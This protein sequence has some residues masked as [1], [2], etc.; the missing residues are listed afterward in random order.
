MAT[1]TASATSTVTITVSRTLTATDIPTLTPTQ[2]IAQLAIPSATPRATLTFTPFPTI[3]PN[4]TGT[5]IAQTAA[6][7]SPSPTQAPADQF[8]STQ[9]FPIDPPTSESEGEPSGG[10]GTFYNPDALPAGQEPLPVAPVGDTGPSGPAPHFPELSS[11][12]ITYAGQVVP[13]LELDSPT[14]A[15]GT[16][17]GRGRMIA[18]NSGGQIASVGPDRSL[19][20]NGQ[21]LDV[22][23]A[24]GFGMP[25]DIMIGD[26]AWSPDGRRLAFRVDPVNR[27]PENTGGSY[28]EPT[29][30]WICDPQNPPNS[31]H[32]FRNGYAGQVAQLHEQRRAL[33]MQWAPN[34]TALVIAVDTPLGRANVFLPMNHDPTVF[35]PS[36]PYADATWAPDSASLIVSGSKDNGPTVI[37]R[38]ALDEQWTYTEY[39]TQV[40]TGLVMQAAIQLYDGRIA[41]LG[42]AT[43]DTFALYITQAAPNAQSVGMSAPIN[44]QVITAEWNAGRTAVLVTAQTGTGQQLW[45]VRTDGQIQNITPNAGFDAAHWQ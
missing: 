31:W 30:V 19:Y 11:I 13:I 22:S 20:I 24:S 1:M 15:G 21:R 27:T 28:A 23:P 29:G 2:A 10:D 14:G 34:S 44:G 6:A 17:P 3:T 33:D 41:F 26:L 36:I 4:L 32:I 18:V 9:P 37:G 39:L 7:F 12:V 38:I 5:S 43:A 42:G 25:P 8:L 35:V 16:T 40:T 45:L